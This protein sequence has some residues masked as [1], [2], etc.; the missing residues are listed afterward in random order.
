ME[1]KNDNICKTIPHS[2][3]IAVWDKKFGIKSGKEKCPECK[4][5]IIY[6]LDFECKFLDGKNIV[7]DNLIP[8][9]KECSSKRKKKEKDIETPL[10][11]PK[12]PQTE[13]TRKDFISKQLRID[14]WNKYI[15][16][17]MGETKC[18]C[19][20]IFKIQQLNF[21]CGH[22]IAESLGG[23]T[24]VDNL[25]PICGSCNKSMGIKNLYEFKK[26]L[27]TKKIKCCCFF[28]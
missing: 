26:I 16:L 9:C 19:C 2:L 5:N 15:G 17:N 10:I 6:Q 7:L 1:Q 22:I 11:I 13:K 25:L 28:L 24:T 4:N 20:G 18:L 27:S 21:E 3:Y 8:A 23:P 12:S 14:V